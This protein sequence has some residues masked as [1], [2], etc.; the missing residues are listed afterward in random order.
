MQIK[1]VDQIVQIKYVDQ[2][3]LEWESQLAALREHVLFVR[4]IRLL[5]IVNVLDCQCSNSS[6][7]QREWYAH[8]QKVKESKKIYDTITAETARRNGALHVDHGRSHVP[9]W[10]LKN[11][12]IRS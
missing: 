1:Y 5:L 7:D 6:A 10:A 4:C 2:Q 11:K 8:N 9:L 12:S 3:M